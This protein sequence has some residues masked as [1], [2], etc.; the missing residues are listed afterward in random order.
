MGRFKV[1]FSKGAAKDY[2]RLPEDY[3][4]LVD[5]ALLKLSEGLPT[6]IKPITG[7]KDSY[8]IRI[9]KYRI[10]FAIIKDK[11][12]FLVTKIGPRGD[13]YK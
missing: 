5:L 7:E 13:V 2:R 6:D 4:A 10:L 3:K 1:E 8:R 9:G 11:N 12:A